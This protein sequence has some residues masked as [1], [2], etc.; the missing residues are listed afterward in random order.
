M[1]YETKLY[2]MNI[3]ILGFFFS[4]M[5]REISFLPP[6]KSLKGFSQLIWDNKGILTVMQLFLLIYMY[7]SSLYLNLPELNEISHRM[8]FKE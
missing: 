3:L 2:C 4:V 1:C 6:V 5:L 8:V 7:F